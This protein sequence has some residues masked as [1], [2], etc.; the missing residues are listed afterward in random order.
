MEKINLLPEVVK[1]NEL[2]HE[3]LANPDAAAMIPGAIV[4]ALKAISDAQKKPLEYF[5]KGNS[6]CLKNAA[7]NEPVFV[8]RGQDVSAPH[9]IMEWINQNLN[10]CPIE[11][12]Q[13]AWETVKAMKE[14]QRI[15]CKMAD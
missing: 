10:T 7:E 9:I 12:L 2:A 11:K 3:M 15:N 5:A 4:A 6:D 1:L 14:F 13:E 8:L